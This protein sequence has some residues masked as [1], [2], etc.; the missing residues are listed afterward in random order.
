MH[1]LELQHSEMYYMVLYRINKLTFVSYVKPGLILVLQVNS[2]L[3]RLGMILRGLVENAKIKRVQEDLVVLV[4]LLV[5]VLA[6][7]L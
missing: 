4:L 7:F 3:K 1:T 6:I 5:N 2:S